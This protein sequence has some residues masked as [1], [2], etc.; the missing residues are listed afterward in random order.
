M[1]YTKKKVQITMND[2]DDIPLYETFG[3]RKMDSEYIWHHIRSVRK[4]N[5]ENMAERVAELFDRF[6]GNELVYAL[7]VLGKTEKDESW[8]KLH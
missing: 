6:K 3:L 7:I 8:Q 2:A 4:H 5:T 1:I